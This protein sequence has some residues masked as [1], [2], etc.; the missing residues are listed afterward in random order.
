MLALF[1]PAAH[2]QSAFEQAMAQHNQVKTHETW[3]HIDQLSLLAQIGAI[4]AL[5]A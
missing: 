4:P 5:A 3:L 2:S 1:I